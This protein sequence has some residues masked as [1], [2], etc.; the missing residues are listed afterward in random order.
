MTQEKINVRRLVGL[1]LQ[2]HCSRKKWTKD[3]Q[4]RRNKRHGKDGRKKLLRH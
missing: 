1:L 2:K 3:I 4:G